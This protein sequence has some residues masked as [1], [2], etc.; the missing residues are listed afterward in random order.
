MI[1]VFVSY[2]H[3]DREVAD[4]L[5]AILDDLSI[6]YF[7]DER[8]IEWGESISSEVKLALSEAFAVIVVVSPGSLKSQW[9]AYETGYASALDK[10]I[11]PFLTHPDLD[12]PGYM[13][14][15]KNHLDV[16]EVR[17]YFEDRFHIE[18]EMV[19]SP[20]MEPEVVL[21][22]ADFGKVR[23]L[24]PEL[25]ME[26]KQDLD[27]DE[28]NLMREFVLLPSKNI[29]FNSSKLRFAYFEDEHH[30]LIGKVD[31]LADHGYVFDVTPGNTPIYRMTEEFISLVKS[32]DVA[33]Q[34]LAG[35][36]PV[37]AGQ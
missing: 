22:A 19:P 13:R 4:T 29:P 16:A 7:R 8:S 14:D 35:T 27:S 36:D 20:R 11:L 21:E 1:D 3:S 31:I 26:I 18:K 24:M 12:V 23:S 15:L 25:I 32:A 17:S 37:S 33:G 34:P 28:S 6:P 2:S 9:V 30:N 10:R 5:C